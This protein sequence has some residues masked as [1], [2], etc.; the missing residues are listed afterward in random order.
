MHCWIFNLAILILKYYIFS[1][2]AIFLDDR[3]I[4]INGHTYRKQYSNKSSVVW[5]CS[6]Y[7]RLKCRAS[8]EMIDGTICN[9]KQ[10]HNHEPKIF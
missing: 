1:E 8:F 10:E 6:S 3:R 4:L 9:L 5:Y 2:A 7:S